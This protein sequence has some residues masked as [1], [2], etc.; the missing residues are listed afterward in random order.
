MQQCGGSQGTRR[1]VDRGD[2]LPAPAPALLAPER[3]ARQANQT[4]SVSAP[5]TVLPVSA[6]AA[7][8]PP[9]ARRAGTI[10]VARIN[11]PGI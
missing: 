8:L 1:G 7:V 3:R 11:A 4:S 10:T 6:P 5:A 2:P 9:S